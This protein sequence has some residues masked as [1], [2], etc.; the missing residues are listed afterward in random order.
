MRGTKNWKYYIFS[1][2]LFCLQLHISNGNVFRNKI[3]KKTTKKNKNHTKKTKRKIM[4]RGAIPKD[5]IAPGCE[6]VGETNAPPLQAVV[7]AR[8]GTVPPIASSRR[9]HKQR[10]WLAWSVTDTSS[11]GFFLSVGAP[12][13]TSVFYAQRSERIDSIGGD[14]RR[15]AKKKP[16]PGMNVLCNLKKKG[17]LNKLLYLVLVWF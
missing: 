1:M 4:K 10:W 17:F 16:R 8:N 12:L 5:A 11:P 14:E 7:R 3:S 9:P 13:V 6:H 2:F 15:R